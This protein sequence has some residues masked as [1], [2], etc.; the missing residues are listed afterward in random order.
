MAESGYVVQAQVL[1]RPDLLRVEQIVHITLDAAGKGSTDVTLDRVFVNT[2]AILIAKPSGSV[3]GVYKAGYLASTP[4]IT[5]TT[6]PATSFVGYAG[7]STTS[8]DPSTQAA[9]AEGSGFFNRVVEVVLYAIE[10]P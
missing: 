6:D 10:A 2:P 9:V 8:G 7:I 4:K 3:T 1:Q 5:V